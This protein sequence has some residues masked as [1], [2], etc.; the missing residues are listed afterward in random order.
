MCVLPEYLLHFTDRE[1]EKVAYD[2]LWSG[3][4]R[5]IL[6]FD[7][8]AGNGKTTLI[9][10]LIATRCRNVPHVLVDFQ[11]ETLRTDFTAILGKLE[12]A[13]LPE[14]S[15]A[16][17]ETYRQRRNAALD[18][19]AGRRFEISI[20]Q[21]QIAVTHE[22]R[23]ESSQQEVQMDLDEVYRLVERTARRQITT[24]WLETVSRLSDRPRVV[25]LDTFE[26]LEESGNHELIAWL[27]DELLAEM[28]A[29]S[30]ALRV[31]VASRE[32]IHRPIRDCRPLAIR[33]FTREQSDELLAALGVADP[34]FQA[35]VFN[36]L[37]RG[38]P[39]VTEMAAEAWREGQASGRLLVATSVPTLL[40]HERA[41]EWL[42]GGIIDRLREPLNRAVRWAALLRRF[43]LQTLQVLLPVRLSDDDFRRLT[44][45]SFVKPARET[46]GWS[47]HELVRRVQV[48]YLRKALPGDFVEFHRRAAGYFNTGRPDDTLE[49]LYHQ[50]LSDS[51]TAA[52][53]RWL[54]ETRSAYSEFDLARWAA[55]LDVAESP[56]LSL[57]Q[58]LRAGVQLSR[59]LWLSKRGEW[60]H[61][62]SQLKWAATGFSELDDQQA[63]ALA[64]SNLGSIERVTDRFEEALSHLQHALEIDQAL[65]DR[66]G[67]AGTLANLG[68]TCR[69]MG[70]FGEALEHLQRALEIDK[71]LGDRR[72][73]A[74][75]LANLGITYQAMGRFEEA[76]DYLKHAL[77][78]DR[79]LGDRRGEA[80]TLANLGITYQAMGRF[81]E[82]LDYLKHALE[83]NRALGDRR[84][85]ASAL[86]NLG[87]TCRAMGRFEEALEH[88]QHALELDRALGDRRGEAGTLANLGITYQA[89]RRF[90]EAV[91]HLQRAL[92][93]NQE[94]GDRR[95]EA[96]T[97]AN[98]GITYQAMGRF[99]EALEHLQRALEI[100]QALGDR[101]GEASTLANLGLTYQAMGRFEEALEHLDR[102]LEIN[103]LLGDKEA[104]TTARGNIRRTRGLLR[105][106]P[107]TLTFKAKALE[108]LG[109]YGLALGFLEAALVK[110]ERNAAPE[111]ATRARIARIQRVMGRFEEALEHLQRALEID[112][113]LGDRRG[114]AGTLAN[115]GITYQAMGRFEEALEHLQ[116][117]LEI[118][119]A[120]GDRQGEAGTLANLG[121]TY[122]AMGRFEEALEHLQR[123]LEINQ[124]LGDRQGGASALANLGITYQA[125]GRFEEALDHLQRA[126]EIDQA[127]GDRR[128]EASA[129]GSLGTIYQ[130]MGRFEEALDHL[131]RALEIDQGL[132]DR[133]WE[134]N[135]LD[136]LGNAYAALGE[137]R[138]AI[139]YY[140]RA[141]TI[142]E[143]IEDPDAERVRRSLAELRKS[144]TGDRAE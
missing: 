137:V 130:A 6:V 56:E 88:L 111:A 101:R 13:F 32:P 74:S 91:D 84:G 38:H 19:L 71:A 109:H 129:L 8:L 127:L 36:R 65:G 68:I 131:Q 51:S 116:R 34:A 47:F 1:A 70:R 27:C 43:D 62:I 83:I 61:A 26:R 31:I 20:E 86:A 49:L 122:Q 93:I 132:G 87:I 7:G 141:L 119:R 140:E 138:R 63:Q 89:M 60:D 114:E 23:L 118:N 82:A 128:G 12:T 3:D 55:L 9:D 108:Q 126:L 121:I 67:E 5:W 17:V 144:T 95:G 107:A 96:G 135:R 113:A 90:R 42:H 10:Y 24:A 72:G 110:R 105:G 98:L 120:L 142:F 25:F 59:G 53:E 125:M 85:E 64:L 58:K 77:E 112:Q 4:G 39:L 50:F 115:L 14:L 57:P 106:Q 52:W 22:A 66:R 104:M 40:A 139:E 92:E 79:V 100:N 29:R 80:G 123:A 45:Y 48:T 97:L 18:M 76:L 94:L 46:E 133:R 78:I 35:A 99:G 21:R 15:G 2:G 11:G 44:R 75:A 117:A 102:A 30:P 103:R 28:H 134:G 136:N 73:E 37:A 69:A 54:Q 81:G 143:A 124:E 16:P 33:E 41:V